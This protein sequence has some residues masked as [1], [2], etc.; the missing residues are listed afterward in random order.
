M[1]FMSYSSTI[2]WSLFT[3]GI[4]TL[5]LTVLPYDSVYWGIALIVVGL[6]VMFR[7]VL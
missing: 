2:G 1:V 4:V 3:S 5:L 6:V 7:R